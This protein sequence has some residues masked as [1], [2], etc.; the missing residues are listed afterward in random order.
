MP[1]LT[2]KQKQLQTDSLSSM[3]HADCGLPWTQ[4][5]RHLTRKAG[6]E[7]WAELL[8]SWPTHRKDMKASSLSGGSGIGPLVS[9]ARAADSTGLHELGRTDWAEH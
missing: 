6:G 7:R 9:S 1:L 4:Q 5:C 3:P 2:L 8:C